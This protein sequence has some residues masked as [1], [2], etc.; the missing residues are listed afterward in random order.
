MAL[1]RA[2]LAALLLAGMAPSAMVAALAQTGGGSSTNTSEARA[3][4]IA[5]AITPA[6]IPARADADEKFAQTVQRRVQG[7]AAVPRHDAALSELSAA[8]DALADFTDNADLT[9]LSVQRLESLERHWRV[10]E[11]AIDQAR[12]ELAR[13]TNA[14]SEDAADLTQRRAAWST[15]AD[16]PNLSPALLQRSL[17]LV[18][19][20]DRTQ[21]Q[22]A[23]PLAQLIQL[24]RRGNSL[25]ARVQAGL[26]D[27]VKQVA[28]QDRQLVTV[29]APLLWRAA[30]RSAA[31][32]PVAVAMQRSLAIEIAFAQAHDAAHSRLLPALGAVA[33]FLLPMI[34]WLRR[35]ARQLVAAG[36]LDASV[37]PALARPW[38]AWLLL[39]AA[40]AVLYDVQ[41]PTLRQQA[42][43]VLAWIPVLGLLQRRILSLVGPWAY[44]S[45]MFYLFNVVVSM[46]VSNEWIYRVLLLALTLTMLITLGWHLWR[47]RTDESELQ[48]PGHVWMA[49]RWVACGVLVTAAAANIL[50]NVSLASMLPARRPSAAQ[51]R[52]LEVVTHERTDPSQALR[53]LASGSLLHHARRV[54]ARATWSDLVLPAAQDRQ[55]RALVDRYRLA[56]PGPR[57]VAPAP[58]SLPGRRRALL[59]CLRHR[60]D[61]ER[62]GDRRGARHRPVPGRPVGAWSASTSARPRRT[63]RRS[64]PQPTRATTC[65][66]S[67]RPT[68]C[69]AAARRSTTPATVT[70]TWRCP[71]CCSASRRTTASWC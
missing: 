23:V 12:V 40:M 58:L 42:V 33:L 62:R 45:A 67:T 24:G 21:D 1:R 25:A 61:H 41:G 57:R 14:A 50:G 15:T 28:E 18:E 7:A 65:C 71:T 53:R 11:R 9:Q 46:L 6:D 22:L 36:A 44:L 69:S 19:L 31:P 43:M 56:R 37:Q 59:R 66:S 55:L 26:S 34:F 30:E 49:L 35:R 52:S 29:D 10:N 13:D 68:R 48:L 5:Q 64:S 27:V 38:A 39:V 63:S 4:S 2:L 8:V 51:L 16:E 47:A 32:E 20:L 54:E 17:E 70:P 60:Q 3:Q